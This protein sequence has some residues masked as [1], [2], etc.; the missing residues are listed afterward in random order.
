MASMQQQVQSQ[1]SCSAHVVYEGTVPKDLMAIFRRGD[2]FAS[3]VDHILLLQP[4]ANSSTGACQFL[5]KLA[6]LAESAIAGGI[7]TTYG[8]IISSSNSTATHVLMTRFAAPQQVEQLLQT[9]ACAAV[10]QRDTRVP[11][12]AAKS[13]CTS[14]QPIGE[15]NKV[16]RVMFG[17]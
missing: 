13:L 9:P 3:G 17:R 11:L 15:T 14:I 16:D 12:V 1:C 2:E 10:L 7:Q 8:P 6:A 5:Q 4:N